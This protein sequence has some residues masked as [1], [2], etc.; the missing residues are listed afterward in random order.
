MSV[1]EF[2]RQVISNDV[3]WVSFITNA[4]AQFLKP[5]THWRRTGEFSWYQMSQAGGMPSSHSAMVSALAVGVGVE[6]GF[7][8]AYFAIATVFA[9]IITFD[10]GGIR[11]QTGT[12]A[13][14]LNEIIAELLSGHPL[15]SIHL[16]E[17]MGHSRVEVL[18]GLLFGVFVMLLWKLVLQPWIGG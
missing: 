18:A 11:R 15:N 10:A 5:F 9:A 16:K 1:V 3:L 7:D 13:R 4:L 14:L 12:H 6:Q 17:V 2:L 8:S